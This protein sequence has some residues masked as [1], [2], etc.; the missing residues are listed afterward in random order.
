MGCAPVLVRRLRQRAHIAA[1]LRAM[2]RACPLH[3]DTGNGNAATGGRESRLSVSTTICQDSTACGMCRSVN[4]LVRRGGM[5]CH[6]S[7]CHMGDAQHDH[8]VMH[9]IGPWTVA[10]SAL[11]QG[12]HWPRATMGQ[13]AHEA[14]AKFTLNNL[15]PSCPCTWGY[16]PARCGP[17]RCNHCGPLQ[18]AS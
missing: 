5:A 7:K 16:E 1:R 11:W 2:Q 15:L 18:N 12:V 4:T 13:L 8:V 17:A 6:M 9:N 10:H 3:A 14:C